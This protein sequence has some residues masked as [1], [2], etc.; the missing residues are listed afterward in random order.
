MRVSLVRRLASN[1]ARVLDSV[2]DAY[3]AA[4][5]TAEVGGPKVRLLDSLSSSH[6]NMLNMVLNDTLGLKTP[7]LNPG[8]PLRPGT[9]LAFFNPA[10]PEQLLEKDGYHSAFGP[11]RGSK[12]ITR[13]WLGGSITFGTQPLLTD[14]P[15]RCIEYTNDIKGSEETGRMIISKHRAMGPV[16]LG[17]DPQKYHVLEDRILIHIPEM[18]PDFRKKTINKFVEPVA[19]SEGYKA[20]IEFRPSHLSLFR[21]SALS[22]NGHRIHYDVPYATGPSENFPDVVVHGPFQAALMLHWVSSL[23]PE[24]I[25]HYKYTNRVPLFPDEP[26]KFHAVEKDGALTVWATNA[27]GS[28]AL[29][30]PT[31]IPSHLAM[32]D[33]SLKH[34]LLGPSLLKAGQK[35]VDQDEVGRL[36]YEASKGSKFFEAE[37]R[38]DRRLQEEIEAFKAQIAGLD[39]DTEDVKLLENVVDAQIRTLLKDKTA[40]LSRIIVH[41][42]CDAF[43]ASVEELDDPSLKGKPM[44][45]GGGGI[46][47]TCNYEARKCGCRSAM[48]TFIAKKLCPDLILVPSHF[49]R[50]REKSREIQ[51]ILAEYDPNYYCPSADEAFLDITDAYS[52]AILNGTAED[53]E[54]FVSSIRQKIL[55]TTQ[56]T[57]SAGIGPNCRVAKIASNIN[58]PNG[59]Y[60]VPFSS[61]QEVVEFMSGISVRQ[62]GG[63]GRVLERKLQAVGLNTFKEFYELR[64]LLKKVLS[65]SVFELVLECYLGLGIV[66]IDSFHQEARKSLGHEMTFKETSNT[67]EIYSKLKNIAEELSKELVE[68]ELV[69]TVL[70]LKLKRDDFQVITRQTPLGRPIY[71]ADD[72]YKYGKELLDKEM[73]ICVRLMGLKLTKLQTKEMSTRM[74]GF[75]KRQRRSE[76]PQ[77]QGSADKG[78]GES[79]L[80]DKVTCFICSKEIPND[81]VEINEHIDF[82]LSRD[83]IEKAKYTD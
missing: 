65:P 77:K 26:V 53:V 68:K 9:H 23:V 43:F 13:M 69:G 62:V 25:S 66:D 8:D 63:I 37:Q 40:D 27:R 64:G 5:V 57:V 14:S 52:D 75:L 32:D 24:P 76:S 21:F 3:E 83:A 11:P 18:D 20:E 60:Y 34:R 78:I 79:K 31:P 28:M 1:H 56:L 70:H 44:A 81:I 47:S 58:K 49:D 22:F 46:L 2:K 16:D 17:D 41:I 4:V 35:G 48:A 12:L 30:G 55:D 74:T 67:A 39:R 15:N 51:T 54:T 7:F 61:R 6:A 59:Q 80:D 73:P 29:E 82:C 42:D 50:Y 33:E 72:L 36:I 10:Y 19:V 71:T 38:R 45:V